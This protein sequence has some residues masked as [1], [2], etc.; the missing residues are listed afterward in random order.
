MLVVLDTML[1]A[2]LPLIG[3][4]GTA[5]AI[6]T[7]LTV[8]YRNNSVDLHAMTVSLEVSDDDEAAKTGPYCFLMVF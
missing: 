3:V 2:T 4:N 8:R 6:K 1:L 7:C 5:V